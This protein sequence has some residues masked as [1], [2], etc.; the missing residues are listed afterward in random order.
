MT[1][2]L[3][4]HIPFCR[5]RCHYCHFVRLE[6]PSPALRSRYLEALLK[7]ILHAREIYGALEFETLYLGGGTPSILRPDELREILETL[8]ANFKI[9]EKAEISCE[10]NPGD[11]DPEMLSKPRGIRI[12]RI[13]LG[14]QSFD[15][16][17]LRTLGRRHSVRDTIETL[18]KIRGA[19]IANISLDLMLRIP[20][21][22]AEIFRDSLSQCIALK[23]S[24]VSLYDLEV[25]D[26]TEFG[27]ML[28]RGELS[29]PPE[30]SHGEMYSDAIDSLAAAGYDHYEISNFAIPGF[31]SRHNLIYWRNQEYLGLGPGSFSYL[32]GVRYQFAR[33]VPRYLEKCEA[34][35]WTNDVED[36]LSPRDRATETFVTALRLKE[37]VR[38]NIVSHLSPELPGR[39]SELCKEGLLE[40]SAGNLRLTRR[41][42]FLCED[43]FRFL[44]RKTQG[45]ADPAG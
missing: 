15:D 27:K 31:A 20:G 13:S 41:G 28:G 32:N 39:I 36:L 14:V 2:G 11:G 22:T 16:N 25:H 45:A 37:G 29:L 38:E 40:I 35:I 1:K 5:T 9:S 10:W 43:V 21:Q 33:D 6:D 24:Q 23:V 42:Q 8:T 34:G 19:G 30:A 4:V 7:E 3:Y 17:L 26:D 44:L 18:E 12:N